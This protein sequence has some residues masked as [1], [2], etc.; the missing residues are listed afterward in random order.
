MHIGAQ[1]AVLVQNR[2]MSPAA[3]PEDLVALKRA[4]VK[5]ASA[6][7]NQRKPLLDGP[8][9]QHYLPRFYL[10]GFTTDGLVAVYDREKNEVRKQQPKDTAVIGHFY[11]MEDA[12]GRRRFEIEALLSEYESKASPVIK[13]L[14]AKGNIT[15]DERSDLAIF[16]A[17]GAMRT[18]DIVQSLQL[19][20]SD[21][22]LEMAKRIYA[23][24]DRVEADLRLNPAYAGKSDEEVR[25]EAEAMVNLVQTDGLSVTTNEK[26]AVGMAIKMSLAVAPTFAGRDWV[27]VHR[28]NDR[29]S[30]VTTDAPVV[31]TTTEPRE[32]SIYGIGFGNADALVAFPLTQS[33][34]LMML[35]SEGDFRHIE[36]SADKMRKANLAMAEKCKRFVIGRDEALVK[37]LVEEVDLAGRRWQP[38]MQRT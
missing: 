17:L 15:A 18:P 12:A 2:R 35:G 21:M 26:W 32:S 5:I 19:M 10:D 4:T 28:D 1:N 3:T 25:V 37:S 7:S 29:K 13:K 16:M 36:V 14:A 33:C 24:V 11:T 31:L 8:K 30:F 34:V 27:I 22:T 38:K 20:N 6:E 23:D 9:R